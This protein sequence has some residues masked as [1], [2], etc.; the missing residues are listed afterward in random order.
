MKMPRVWKTRGKSLREES[1]MRGLPSIP[2]F[3]C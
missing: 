2:R 1:P 3:G